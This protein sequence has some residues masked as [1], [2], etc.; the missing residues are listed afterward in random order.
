MC[1]KII[2]RVTKK[3][4]FNLL[5]RRYIL[6]KTTGDDGEGG[7]GGQ[8]DPPFLPAVLGIDNNKSSNDLFGIRI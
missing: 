4:R 3:P 5:F 2:L 1:L 6:Q 8:N 7:G